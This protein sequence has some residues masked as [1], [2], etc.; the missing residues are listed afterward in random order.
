MSASDFN[1][2]KNA[3]DAFFADPSNASLEHDLWT[4]WVTYAQPT[5]EEFQKVVL[6]CLLQVALSFWSMPRSNR[7]RGMWAVIEIGYWFTYFGVPASHMARLPHPC[8]V[9]KEIDLDASLDTHDPRI[10]IW[11]N[12]LET[13]R[14]QIVGRIGPIFAIQNNQIQYS[15]GIQEMLGRM[16][17]A[18]K[19]E[20][21][22]AAA[23]A[24]GAS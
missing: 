5:P 20:K 14:E 7:P 13:K 10:A 8:Q 15:E 9:K 24:P 12:Y 4:L 21:D 17:F 19:R 1:N 23:S 18:I 11:R 22:L 16:A 6:Q 2:L 3:A